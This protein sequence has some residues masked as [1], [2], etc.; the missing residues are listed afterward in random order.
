MPELIEL[1]KSDE[2]CDECGGVMFLGIERW[3]PD[4]GMSY[5]FA[6]FL[7]C[8]DCGY[9]IYSRDELSARELG[10]KIFISPKFY[11]KGVCCEI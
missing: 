3:E 7:R 8:K 9:N 6:D 1:R 2:K 5:L 11:R 4:E 10:V